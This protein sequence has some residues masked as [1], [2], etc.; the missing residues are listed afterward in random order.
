[1]THSHSSL[2]AKDCRENS[3]THLLKKIAEETQN[4]WNVCILTSLSFPANP[5]LTQQE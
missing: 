4:N 5:Q 3:T 2:I 1:M